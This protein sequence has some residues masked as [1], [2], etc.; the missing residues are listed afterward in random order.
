MA[1]WSLEPCRV[2][3]TKDVAEFSHVHVEWLI[4]RMH[5]SVRALVL[6]T[7]AMSVLEH[8]FSPIQYLGSGWGI[9]FVIVFAKFSRFC[10]YANNPRKTT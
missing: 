7:F 6:Q 3:L 9:T 1:E 8:S 5:L 2:V 4:L 10:S